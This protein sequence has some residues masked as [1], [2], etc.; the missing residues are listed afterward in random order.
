MGDEDR[1]ELE[2]L[3][4]ALK[5][6]R[7]RS[8][9]GVVVSPEV[10]PELSPLF[11]MAMGY[12]GKEK[13][14]AG[15][16]ELLL[17]E[18]AAA[19]PSGKMKDTALGIYALDRDPGDGNSVAWRRDVKSALYPYSSLNTYEDETEPKVIR[20]IA[21]EVQALVRY[22]VK[23]DGSGD[24]LLTGRPLPNFAPAATSYIQRPN[25]YNAFA[26]A[27][28]TADQG[29]RRIFVAGDFGTGKTRLVQE[30]IQNS[31]RNPRVIWIN[32]ATKDAL[33]SSIVQ[34]LESSGIRTIGSDHAVLKHEFAR[35]LHER[36]DGNTIVVVDN[37]DDPDLLDGLVPV[38]APCAVIA[39]SRLL[40]SDTSQPHVLVDDMKPSE[41]TAM[42]KS[43]L[44]EAGDV[45]ASG[46]AIALGYR[47]HLIANA[48]Q[49]LTKTPEL[50]VADLSTVLAADTAAG[51]DAIAPRTVDAL[52]V[53]YRELIEQLEARHPSSLKLLE[54]LIFASSAF[55]PKEYLGSFL[56]EKPFLK[57]ADSIMAGIRLD[58]ALR[59]LAENCLVVVAPGMV[60]MPLAV[61]AV[62][63]S[64]LG[65]RLEPVVEAARCLKASRDE[66]Y[67][68]GWTLFT[69]TGRIM[70]DRVLQARVGDRSTNR[71][72]E[73][74]EGEFG[75]ARWV[76][77]TN[78]AW[79]R[80]IRLEMLH[81]A[82]VKPEDSTLVA[83]NFLVLRALLSEGREE[84]RSAIRRSPRLIRED[85]EL[86]MKFG[87]M[88]GKQA[89]PAVLQA[90]PEELRTH[91]M[92]DAPQGLRRLIER[93]VDSPHG[94]V[95]LSVLLPYLAEGKPGESGAFLQEIFPYMKLGSD[96]ETID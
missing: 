36:T 14:L 66:L 86:A 85:F 83:K 84:A 46:L 45:E 81:L 3:V 87:E 8:I 53:S 30:V 89:N 70:C 73:F 41:A 33:H 29:D 94:Q 12:A 43:L 63:Q 7:R 4:K 24:V 59:P 56:L 48:C 28:N 22:K 51:I 34:I 67:G 54:L 95:D 74:L 32:A 75:G 2:E 35:L 6:V 72:S 62:M 25:I 60:I 20:L 77:L 78:Q 27:A 19:L 57:S 44:P 21:A 92:A 11:G 55:V 52:T 10:E 61:Q 82:L 96:E 90:T 5:L 50:T 76:R 68:E 80:T 17:R 38:G 16:L 71:V 49:F 13:S 42:V 40:P 23:G 65:H 91:F 64:I 1:K 9:W 26:A 69:V 31:E 93:Y 47:P 58:A 39:I 79:D 37:L 15:A 88:L 18:A